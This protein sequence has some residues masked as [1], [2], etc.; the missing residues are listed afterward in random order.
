MID[1]YTHIFP[2]KFYEVLNRTS[3][4]LGA[5]GA[6][7]R[8]VKPIFDLDARFRDMDAVGADYR[9]VISLPNPPIEDVA[10]PEQGIMLARVANDAMAEL[11]AKHPDR[12]PA[13]AAACC[14]TDVDGSLRE[15]ERAIT[16]L[17]AR[18]VQ[19]FTNIRAS[20]STCRVLGAPSSRRWRNT[21]CRSGFIRR[22]LPT[23]S[24]IT[25][26]S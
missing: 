1:I 14:M 17:G 18:G 5:I 2:D 10:T 21:I 8:G 13:F 6:R 24:P 20:R 22:A 11:C 3:P 4:K 25:A 19:T 23:I 15:I 7:L 26:A 12:F 9:Q 16:Q